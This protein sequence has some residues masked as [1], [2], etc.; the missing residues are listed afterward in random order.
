[1]FKGN[2]FVTLRA[3]VLDPQ[4]GVIKSSLDNLGFNKV[5]DVKAGKFFE[6]WLEATNKED[7]TKELEVISE[8]LLANLIVEDYRVEVVEVEG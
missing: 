3:G 4:G 6:V 8:K 1:M 5:K 2:V 7:A